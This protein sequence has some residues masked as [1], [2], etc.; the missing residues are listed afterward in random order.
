[1]GPQKSNNM[2]MYIIC[3]SSLM[4]ISC[5]IFPEDEVYR[6]DKSI[7]DNSSNVEQQQIAYWRTYGN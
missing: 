7:S 5:G 6:V 4:I 2:K 3:M 1:M